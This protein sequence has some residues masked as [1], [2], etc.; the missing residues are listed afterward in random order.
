MENAKPLISVVMPTFN[1][2][3][4]IEAALQRLL[5][6]KSRY[7]KNI[8]IIVIDGGSKDSTVE[9]LKKYEKDL[10]YWI[11]EPDKGPADAFNKGIRKAQ[12]AYVRFYSDDDQ[13]FPSTTPAMVEHLSAH[14]EID[15]LGGRAEYYMLK[16]SGNLDPFPGLS[17]AGEFKLEDCLDPTRRGYILTE[18]CF[19]KRTLFEEMGFWDPVY[20]VSCDIEFFLRISKAKK[21]IEVLDLVTAKKIWHSD[22]NVFKYMGSA[23]LSLL[24]AVWRY[25]GFSAFKRTMAKDII[26]YFQY[27]RNFREQL[28]RTLWAWACSGFGRRAPIVK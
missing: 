2:G 22:S 18:T 8:E 4:F 16:E 23:K 12:G 20:G 17:C 19:Y 6:E 5:E 7:Y 10:T 13:L 14:P 27:D 21:K 25:G 9:I 3:A 24:L 11:S 26:P 15:V 1:R 28:L